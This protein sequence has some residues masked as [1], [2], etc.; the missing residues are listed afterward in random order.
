M[1]SAFRADE[2]LARNVL[3]VGLSCATNMLKHSACV[4]AYFARPVC[5]CIKQ[6]TRSLRRLIALKIKNGRAPKQRIL[7]F[8][9]HRSDP[10][11]YQDHKQKT[12]DNQ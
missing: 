5:P 3:T 10:N 6:S 1:R 11:H 4:T 8:R 12:D 9:H 7:L 2:R